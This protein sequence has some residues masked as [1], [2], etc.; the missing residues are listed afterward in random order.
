ME[1]KIQIEEPATELEQFL[2][3]YHNCPLCGSELMYTHVTN[4][5]HLSVQEEA[6]CE[7]CNIRTK[8]DAHVLQ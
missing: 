1:V 2:E 8:K 7:P 3:D 4:F 5:A 6:H